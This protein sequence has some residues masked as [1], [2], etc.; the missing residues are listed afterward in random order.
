MAKEGNL[1]KQVGDRLSD[2]FLVRFNALRL[3]AV[4]FNLQQ[5]VK[6]ISLKMN[7][8]PVFMTT[9]DWEINRYLPSF[10]PFIS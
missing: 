5:I 4:D 8:A 1:L 3:L 6:I 2:S 7:H 9:T 10:H